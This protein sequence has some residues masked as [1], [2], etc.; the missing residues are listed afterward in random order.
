MTVSARLQN[1]LEIHNAKKD[2]RYQL[3]VS[4]GLAYYDPESPCSLDDLLVKAD[5][6]MYEQK[7]DKLKS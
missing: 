7:R 6:L 4:V 3:S 2:R 1:F 5:K